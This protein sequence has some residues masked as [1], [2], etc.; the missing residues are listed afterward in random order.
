MYRINYCRREM[1]QFKI[2]VHIVEPGFFKT[3]I[4]DPVRVSVELKNIW[5]QLPQDIRR[6]YGPKYIE[7]GMAVKQQEVFLPLGKGAIPAAPTHRRTPF[8]M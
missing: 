8:F 7:D 4:T 5:Q 3:D 2:S 1:R 6:L